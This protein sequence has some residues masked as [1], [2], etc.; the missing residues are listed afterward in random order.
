ML[1]AKGW[2]WGGGRWRKD[3]TPSVSSLLRPGPLVFI[4]SPLEEDHPQAFFYV[5]LMKA[6]LISLGRRERER[7]RAPGPLVET[8]SASENGYGG[9][10][11]SCRGC[12]CKD[13]ACV[14]VMAGTINQETY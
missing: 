5:L 13:S 14:V 3:I 12:G 6:L 9:C 7:E 10:G 2:V 4:I 1:L 11:C 8:L